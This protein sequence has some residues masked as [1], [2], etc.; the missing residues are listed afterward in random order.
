VGEVLKSKVAKDF[1]RTAAQ[2][3]ARGVFKIGRR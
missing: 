3:I 1:M 2:E